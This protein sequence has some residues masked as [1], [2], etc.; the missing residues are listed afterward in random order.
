MPADADQDSAARIRKLLGFLEIDPGNLMLRITIADLQHGSGDFAAAEA[1]FGAVLELQPDH[2]IARSRLAGVYISQHRF[3]EAESLLR[4]LDSQPQPDPAVTH[5]LGIALVYQQR[6][7]EA[8]QTLR[9]AAAAGIAEQSN[10]TYQAYC[11]HHLGKTEEAL[12]AATEALKLGSDDEVLGYVSLLQMDSGDMKSASRNAARVLERD[13]DNAL[14]NLVRGWWGLETQEIDDAE[15]CIDR[16]LAQRPDE[17]RA[18]LGKGLVHLY[19]QQLPEAVAA[20]ERAVQGMPRSPGVHVT[21]GWALIAQGDLVA[22]ERVFRHAIEVEHNFGESHGGLASV[23]ALAGRTEEARESIR[24]ARGLN[25]EGFGVVFAMTVLMSASG[26]E[27]AATRLFGNMLLRSPGGA[28][29]ITLIQALQI[30]NRR[31]G[32]RSGVQLPS[33][34]AH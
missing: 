24:R 5:N 11:L 6:W 30:H 14:A 32:R 28:G 26:K 10:L 23:L 15:E 9:A 19:N 4:V 16:A 29:G 31:Q 34:T 3:E 17:P 12:A 7:E 27:D 33:P 2:A 1:G 8:L 21:L 25:K 13:P 22:A 18:L 20:L